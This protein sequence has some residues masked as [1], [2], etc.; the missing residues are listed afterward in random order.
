ML[1]IG[2]I[3][4]REEHREET[5]DNHYFVVYSP[6]LISGH[7]FFS[8]TKMGSQYTCPYCPLCPACDTG[9]GPWKQFPFVGWLCQ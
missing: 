9:A 8:D 7:K 4:S 2:K 1:I 5:K 3:K 6:S